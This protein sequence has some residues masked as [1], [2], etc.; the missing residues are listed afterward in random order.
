MMSVGAGSGFPFITFVQFESA[1]RAK[2]PVANKNAL[3]MRFLLVRFAALLNLPIAY[4]AFGSF[5]MDRNTRTSIM[6]EVV[7]INDG[8]SGTG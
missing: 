7:R 6:F 5:F 2:Q 8:N 3:F 1:N 4:S